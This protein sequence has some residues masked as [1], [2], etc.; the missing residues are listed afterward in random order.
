MPGSAEVS[1]AELALDF[2]A[3]VG[4]ALPAFPD[5]RLR[6]TRL[7]L[8]ER[9]QLPRNAAGLVEHHLVAGTL[10]SGAP[11]GLCRSLLP[12]GRRVCAGPSARP[13]F[14]ARHEAMLQQDR[15]A[16]AAALSS[17]LGRARLA[18]Q[19]FPAPSPLASRR[20]GAPP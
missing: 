7:P 9:A 16:G 14:T 2:D 6:G 8:G 20:Y 12:L 1:W 4:R 5:H 3:F 15:R 11:L 19:A 18:S 17:W 13:F 10:L